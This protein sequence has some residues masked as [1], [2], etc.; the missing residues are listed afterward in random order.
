M[1]KDNRGGFLIHKL[2]TIISLIEKVNK[3]RKWKAKKGNRDRGTE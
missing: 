1:A 2:N 3:N